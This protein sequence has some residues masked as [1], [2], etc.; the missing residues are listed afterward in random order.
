M[1]AP[2]ARGAGV[3]GGTAL[4]ALAG[5]ATVPTFASFAGLVSRSSAG[6]LSGALGLVGGWH[7]RAALA[8]VLG[9]DFTAVV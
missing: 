9:G 1:A 4:V 6:R 5:V 7:G 8:A 3:T 2:F